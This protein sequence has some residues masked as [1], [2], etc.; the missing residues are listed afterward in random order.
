MIWG[1]NVTPA[2]PSA[3]S[4]I[5]INTSALLQ[6]RVINLKIGSTLLFDLFVGIICHSKMNRINVLSLPKKICSENC[7]ILCLCESFTQPLFYVYYY[8]SAGQA[9]FSGGSTINP[10]LSLSMYFLNWPKL[11]WEISYYQMVVVG[12]IYG[13]FL[14]SKRSS[15][16]EAVRI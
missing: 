10:K 9:R 5:S 6:Q 11:K 7:Q 12:N 1:Q 16:L 14:A 13:I 4:Q 3:S 15:C 2:E 8:V